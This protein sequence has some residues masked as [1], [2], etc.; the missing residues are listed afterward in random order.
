[1]IFTL[2]WAALRRHPFSVVCTALLVAL[3]ASLLGIPAPL[4]LLVWATASLLGITLWHALE[5]FILRG[6]GGRPPSRLE[7]E[8]LD[9]ALGPARLEVVV[10]DAAAP[11]LGRGL[12]SLVV[13]RALLDLYEARP[14]QGLL[15][16]AVEQVRLAS[17]AGELVVWLGNLP[18]LGA[19]IL[20]R[21]LARLGRV[22][23]VV[24]G[25]SLVV[26][27]LLW[28][29]GF[30][31]WAG[32]LFGSAI[33]A[34]LGSALLSSGLA[35]PGLGLLLAWAL[36]PGLQALLA[37]ESRRA[38]RIADQATVE[39]GL[40]WQLL[41]A[42]EILAVAQPLP[43]PDGLLGLL[44]RGGSPLSTRAERVWRALSKT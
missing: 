36:M 28:P 9:G 14:V 35:A 15:T 11:W 8:L 32:R 33:V 37:W 2:T 26:P 4:G 5:P 39:A 41:E 10:L 18:L 25:G 1:M 43:A 44:C 20:G 42:L 6:L 19:W 22:L 23:A 21:W 16:Q 34:L 17:L 13:S 12:R 7:R 38:E 40:G 24:V 27:L 29:A 31:L 3:S 30:V